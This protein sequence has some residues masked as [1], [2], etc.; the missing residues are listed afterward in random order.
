MTDKA[1]NQDALEDLI[2]GH[3]DGGLTEEQEKELADALAASPPAK[4]IFLSYM[5]MEGRLHSL[6]RD[7]F[8]RESA[9]K[10]QKI[11]SPPDGT[12]PVVQSDNQRSHSARS[13]TW[14]A[15]TSLAVSA[16]MTLLLIWGM[17]PS[18]VNASSVLRRAQQAAAELVDRTYRLTL[19][20]LDAESGPAARE[21]MIFVRG[22]GCFVVRPVDG[23]YVMGS[24]GTDYWLA[25]QSG[26][27]WVTGD[28]RTIAPELQRK[29]PNRRLLGLAASPNEPLLMQMSSLLSLI[30]SSYDIELVES[31]DLAEHHVRATLRSKK[32]NSPQVIDFWADADSGVVLRAE[33][34]WQSTIKKR[35]ELVE[36]PTLSD[37]WY[38]YS[39]H[40]PNRQVERLDAAK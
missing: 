25:Q 9:A 15:S 10:L 5:R 12:S 8:L 34:A 32:S 7:G 19:S 27:V 22:G 17:W 11:V 31:V 40:A 13:R 28:F 4:Q 23:S 26:P 3:F 14:A 37:R 24:D 2:V 21:L 39:K 1:K 38:H 18:S 6:G 30:A 20:G 35:F 16:A 36:S 29:I 33:I